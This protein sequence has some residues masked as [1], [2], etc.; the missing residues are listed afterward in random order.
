MTTGCRCV[1]GPGPNDPWW[2]Y[3][4]SVSSSAT[5]TEIAAGLGVS[6]STVSAVASRAA[7]AGCS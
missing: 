7:K 4:L 5:A 6:N 3:V 2:Q 1:V